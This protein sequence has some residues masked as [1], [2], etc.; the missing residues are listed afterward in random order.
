M[1]MN[2]LTTFEHFLEQFK[3]IL[4][5]RKE[6][7]VLPGEKDTDTYFISQGYVSQSILS[8]NGN[9]FTPY[10]FAPKSFFPL[11]CW[12]NDCE[13]LKHE[14]EYTSL[15]PVEVRK[16]PKQKLMN[17]LSENPKAIAAFNDQLMIYSA[18]LLKKLETRVFSD[19]FHMV[20]LELLD[21]EKF[22]GKKQGKEIL[23][24]YWFTHQ[25]IANILGLSREVVTK[26][27]SKLIKKKLISYKTHFIVINDL[28]ALAIELESEA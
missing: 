6:R 12:E 26:Q 14:Y 7:I 4:Y 16:F 20:I 3:P 21:L 25:D 11:I 5:R 15:T 28:D 13:S 17:Y 27:M 10:I 23:I 19:A 8:A 24:N 9:E 18:E 2:K 1:L 22:F